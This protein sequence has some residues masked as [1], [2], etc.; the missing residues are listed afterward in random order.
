L[1]KKKWSLN[2]A[3]GL[4]LLGAAFLPLPVRASWHCN[5]TTVTAYSRERFPGLTANGRYTWEG[6]FA[7]THT[8]SP[9]PW[10]TVFVL[11]DGSRYELQDTGD[12]W[13]EI[14]DPWIDILLQTQAQAI[15]FGRQ[16]LDVEVE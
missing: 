8:W 11:P 14:G 3:C 4:I 15:A 5:A 7:A 9:Y 6:D 12:L 1:S 16:C 2:G 13:G 10:G